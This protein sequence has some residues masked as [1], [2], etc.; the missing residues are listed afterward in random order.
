M[1]R[2]VKENRLE[3]ARK[4]AENPEDSSSGK[5]CKNLYKIG[6][7]IGQGAFS[8]VKYANHKQSGKGFAIK[9]VNKNRLTEADAAALKDEVAIL[10]EFRHDPD[11]D[12]SHIVRLYDTFDGADYFYLVTEVIVG[13]CLATRIDTKGCYTEAD[14]RKTCRTVFE[15][16]KFTHAR[17]V[18]HRDLKLENLLLTSTEDACDIKIIDFGFAKKVPASLLHTMIGTPGYVAPCILEGVGYGTKA[19]VWSLGVILYCMLSGSPPFADKNRQKLFNK[20]RKGA[21]DLEDPVKWGHIS[22]DAKDLI[23]S[24]LTVNPAKRI[25]TAEALEHRWITSTTAEEGEDPAKDVVKD[26]VAASST[27]EECPLVVESDCDSSAS[28]KEQQNNASLA[29]PTLTEM[30]TPSGTLVVS[31]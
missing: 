5:R 13:G 7:K 19:D 15:A 11:F 28:S 14:G 12:K 2:R 26:A 22:D 20:I 25:T 18:A 31:M 9:I 23:R 4:L 17:N 21:F 27:T 6:D 30:N 24:L 16:L 10:Q 29:A 1:Y 8:V 3:A